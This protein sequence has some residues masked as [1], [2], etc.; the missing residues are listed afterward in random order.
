MKTIF[1]LFT[2][3]DEMTMPG[4]IALRYHEANEEFVVHNFNTDRETGTERHY[5]GGGYY[6]AGS[7][8]N[9]LMNALT[10]FNRRAEQASRYTTGGSLDVAKLI[11]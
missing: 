11:S 9:R 6:T 3:G 1:E 2:A 8:A 5:H 4:G 7:P 10:D